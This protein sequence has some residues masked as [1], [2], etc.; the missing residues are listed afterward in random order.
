[1]DVLE[2]RL[3]LAASASYAA[4]CFSAAY[5]DHAWPPARMGPPENAD[6]VRAKLA[7]EAEARHAKKGVGRVQREQLKKFACE[8][9]KRY[10]HSSFWGGRDHCTESG[11]LYIPDTL[12]DQQL[13][14]GIICTLF[15]AKDS[16][17]WVEMC[18]PRQPFIEDIDVLGDFDTGAPPPDELFL[19]GPL[20]DAFWKLQAAELHRIFPGV[21]LELTL[22]TG[23]GW[24][25]EKGRQKA[26]FHA[27]W[28]PIVVDQERAG[29]V[30]RA[31]VAAF[32]IASTSPGPIADFSQHLQAL[33]EKNAWDAV[34][35]ITAVKAGSFRMPFCDKVAKVDGRR[36]REG[37][38][39][40]P[41]NVLRFDFDEDGTPLMSV[42]HRPL[43]LSGEEW[44]ARAS[45]R[46][47]ET[48][49]RDFTPWVAPAS[50]CDALKMQR[51]VAVQIQQSHSGMTPQERENF[52]VIAA[53][54]SCQLRWQR[55]A[56]E[57]G[58]EL[59]RRL[60]DP[61]GHKSS[62][63]SCPRS[64]TWTS[65]NGLA[66]KR[67]GRSSSTSPAER[68]LQAIS[69]P[70]QFHPRDE[71]NRP[72]VTGDIAAELAPSQTDAEA[73]KAQDAEIEVLRLQVADLTVRLEE[74]QARLEE[75]QAAT[76]NAGAA[77]GAAGSRW[78]NSRC[79]IRFVACSPRG[80]STVT[81]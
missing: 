76:H 70:R 41:V 45:V 43:D 42:K 22:F 3:L 77:S 14:R 2:R 7:D 72:E 50:T 15:E 25:K 52:E 9:D 31:I 80:V 81:E 5:D 63:T 58:K 24:H 19:K 40:L 28:S 21:M 35:D 8:E 13:L 44:L 57:L 62:L 1:M 56:G 26:S 16:L 61:C 4:R 71:D 51:S 73:Q 60:G 75:V 68:H 32:E 34:F 17:C 36:C 12:C 66:P 37:R 10:T 33:D 38:P 69:K 53:W 65:G 74:A 54:D 29:A 47:A 18:T 11:K 27:V 20:A 30:R 79:T 39:L 46:F 48:P 78:R 6:A 64:R 59:D 55:D 23:S 49:A 67:V